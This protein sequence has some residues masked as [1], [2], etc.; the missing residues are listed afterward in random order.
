[1]ASPLTL[2]PIQILALKSGTSVPVS[3]TLAAPGT[4]GPTPT[5]T[6]VPTPTPTPTPPPSPT[7]TPTPTPAPAPAFTPSPDGTVIIGMA[8]SLTNSTG[9]KLAIASNGQLDIT[10]RGGAMFVEPTS[11]GVVKIGIL[12]DV[13]YQLNSYNAVY[14][15]PP[16]GGGGALQT[17]AATLG[18]FGITPATTSST[19]PTTTAHDASVTAT[20]RPAG[21][22]TPTLHITDW[23]NIQITS[24]G[25]N[26]TWANSIPPGSNRT[27]NPDAEWEF[28]LDSTNLPAGVPSPFSVNADKHFV[29][30]AFPHDNGYN[31]LYSSGCITSQQIFNQK[32]GYFSA[33]MKLPQT[34][35]FW[36]AFW[37]LPSS[38]VYSG[39]NDIMEVFGRGD[40]GQIQ[41]TMH[42][43]V[44]GNWQN[45]AQWANVTGT[46]DQWHDYAC[47][48]RSDYVT[49]YLDG[50]QFGRVATP[51]GMREANFVLFNLAV[52]HPNTWGP[53]P[54]PGATASM[55]IAELL[56]LP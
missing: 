30:S 31:L 53:T 24:D 13:F 42:G 40:L 45:N 38:L 21:S 11:G 2:T 14:T 48:W 28:Y 6:P 35:G 51:D 49:Y 12:S 9:V 47:D 18:L 23:S 17:S 16:T 25:Q 41:A 32:Y 5:P 1:M 15:Q 26:N 29:V 27:L 33:K 7:P 19:L 50:Q 39:E 37:L 20:P 44:N 55:T 46:I 22:G 54:D 3:M 4:V 52:F 43:A 8:G 34:K 10:P 36:P 56:V